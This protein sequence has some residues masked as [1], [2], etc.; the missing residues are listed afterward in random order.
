MSSGE[1]VDLHDLHILSTLGKIGKKL[2]NK[3]NKRRKVKR[4]WVKPWV[5]RRT[6][7]V[8]LYDEIF[9]E[10]RE[11]FFANFRLYP[12]DFQKLYTKIEHKITKQDTFMRKAIPAIIRLQV[13]LRYLTSGCNYSV[14]EDIF[15]IPRSTL[16]S[17]I[18]GSCKINYF[19]NK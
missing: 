12:E 14:L 7:T 8:Q 18:P 16:S 11:K 15:R 10:D 19:S 3:V 2:K 4:I 6:D 5:L 13:C 1:D 9:T 17:L